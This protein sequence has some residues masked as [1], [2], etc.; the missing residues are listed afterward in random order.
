MSLAEVPRVRPFGEPRDITM[1]N[2]TFTWPRDDSS[3]PVVDGVPVRSAAA[4]PKNAFTLADLTLRFPAGKLSLI[5]GRLGSGK[6]LLLN[7]LLGEADTLTGQVDTPRSAPDAMAL[8]A[9]STVKDEDWIVNDM[10]A[11]VPQQAWLQ[12]AS[13]KDNIIFSSPWN[14][15]RYQEVLEACSLTTDL[16]ILEDGD[17]TEIGEKGLNLSGGQKARVSLARAVYSRAGTL[18]LDDVLSA[19]DAHTAHAIVEDCLNGPILAGRTILLVSHHTALVSPVASYIVALENGDV[20]FSGTREDFVECGLMKELDA[21]ENKPMESP[22]EELK[23][24][25][26][27]NPA[28]KRVAS[29]GGVKEAS[30]PNSETSSIAPEDELTLAGS[31]ESDS[32]AKKAK[33]PR[34]LIED[35]KRATG[36]IAWAV[37]RTYFTV[38]PIQNEMSRAEMAQALGGKV[39]WPIF[40][41]SLAMSMVVPL[42][43]KGWLQ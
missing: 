41:L 19:V 15:K 6:S 2:V 9:D 39:W 13:I 1:T 32:D 36:R 26:L 22:I 4:T 28:L 34:K 43:E 27:Q 7:G 16:E 29:L 35:E 17:Q 3:T 20:K 40:I 12:N 42:A 24:S 8:F 31:S 33:A 21:D 5:C 38:S 10:V 30:E 23:Q 25:D 18:L 11:Y 37:W 14:E